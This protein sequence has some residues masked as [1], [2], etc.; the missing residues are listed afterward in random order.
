MLLCELQQPETSLWV[1]PLEE[2]GC[3]DVEYYIASVIQVSTTKKSV[4]IC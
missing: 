2:Q 4:M 1:Q 3:H